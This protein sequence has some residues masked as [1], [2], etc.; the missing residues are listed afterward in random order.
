MS[1]AGLGG[2][3][4][5]LHIGHRTLI[6][7]AFEVADSV[8]IGVTSDDF[9]SRKKSIAI[10]LERR[11]AAIQNY[12]TSKSKPWSILFIDDELGNATTNQKLTDLVVSEGTIANAE[13]I[14]QIRRKRG[15]GPVKLHVVPHVL[16][17]DFMPVSS[18]RVLAGE[19]DPNGHL[20]RPLIVSVGS[21]NPIKLDAVRNVMSR[22]HSNIEIRSCPSASN[23]SEQPWAEETIRGA[24]GRA[25]SAMNDA[26]LGIGIE[27]GVWKRE[28]GLFD[29]QF[30]AVIDRM[31]RIT[32]G[33]GSGF[34]YPPEVEKMVERGDS[35]GNSFKT[36]YGWETHHKKEG[37]IGYLSCGLLSRTE[38]TEQAVLA[39]MI[40]RLRKE[41]YFVGSSSSL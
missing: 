34:Q 3:F 13:R 41:L 39:A 9:A 36:L 4:N 21:S 2:T 24:V 23:V 18:S 37:A 8:V 17:D 15:M 22:I 14:N 6:D 12:L 10:P 32:I 35:V 31:G 20:K 27:A 16:A 19:I 38:L 40:P 26:D 1:L 28:Y 29:I 11:V 7:K 25:S 33:Q 5:V 30:C